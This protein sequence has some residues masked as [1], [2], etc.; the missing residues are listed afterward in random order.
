MAALISL[1]RSDIG[2]FDGLFKHW[3][4]TLENVSRG[5]VACVRPRPKRPVGFVCVLA[6]DRSPRKGF[7][8]LV[9]LG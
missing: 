6:G 4:R 8:R 2:S 1:K 3:L 5:G 7:G 9:S